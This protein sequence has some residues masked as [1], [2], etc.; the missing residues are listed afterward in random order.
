MIR[1]IDLP[2]FEMDFSLE[3][4]GR[5]G[6][7]NV[8]YKDA[9]GQRLILSLYEPPHY[10]AGGSYPLLVL[11][12]GGGWQSR[13]VFADQAEWAGDYLGFLACRYAEKSA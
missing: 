6:D 5:S 11:V 12:H 2:D 4:A 8:V 13:K 9:D 10:E 1:H 3:I 7:K